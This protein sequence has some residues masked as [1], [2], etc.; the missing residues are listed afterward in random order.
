MPL[1]CDTL[2]GKDFYGKHR[3]LNYREEPVER[4]EIVGIVFRKNKWRGDTGAN[5]Q[6]G[7]VN[8]DI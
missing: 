1:N 4:K 6:V 5:V 8:P 2:K 7:D 3:S